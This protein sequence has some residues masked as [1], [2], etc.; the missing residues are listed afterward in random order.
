MNTR[1]AAIA[2][3]AFVLAACN[4]GP[5]EAAAPA[6]GSKPA[7]GSQRAP[8]AAGD[9][10]AAVLQSQ[11]TPIATLSYLIETRPV[12][13]QP[14]A[15]KLL[16][17]AGQPLPTLQLAAE[18]P[19]LIVAPASGTLAIEA[20]GT[21]VTHELIV[22]APKDGLAEVVVKLKASDEPETVYALAVLVSPAAP[23]GG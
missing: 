20:A 10:V 1:V 18:S 6:S 19:T 2:A 21:P 9:A 23:A 15:L 16:V 12:V 14:F 8:A 4:K 3:A 5:D 17:T 7:A 22:T 13:G 11:G